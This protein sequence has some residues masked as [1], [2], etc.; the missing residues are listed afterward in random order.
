[1]SNVQFVPKSANSKIGSIPCTTSARSTCPAACPLSGKNGC[2]AEAGYYTRM[3]W[4]KVTSGERGKDWES[5]LA[6][7]ESLKPQ[8]LWR[9]NVAGDL[10]GSDN[11][12]DQGKLDQLAVAN[13]GKR[14]FTYTHYPDTK[15]NLDAIRKAEKLGFT[16]NLSAN[17]IDHAMKLRKHG[18]PIASVV[19]IDH[20]NKTRTI[21]GVKFITCP[22]TYRDNV[23]CK[24]CKLCSIPNRNA[25]IAFPAHGTQAKNANI[26]A[27]G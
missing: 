24:T 21:D 22:A 7:V 6:S 27:T 25:V 18:L 12:I 17:N 20:G 1:M 14:G 9:H 26:I 13:K 19:P 4:D 11:V 3:N 16:I 15:P 8:T 10:Q 23:T 2:Y 5:F